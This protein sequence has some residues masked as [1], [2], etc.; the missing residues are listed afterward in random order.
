M[1]VISCLIVDDEPLAVQLLENHIEQMP[2]LH[3]EGSCSNAMEALQFI[4]S[5]SVD[6]I[7]L[8]IQ[9]PMLSGVDFLKSIKNPPK[10]IFTT[11]FREY[12]LTGYE[13][14]IVDYLLKPITFDRF[15]KA[16]NKYIKLT[17]NQLNKNINSALENETDSKSYIF[18]NV[19][20]K[21][22]KI[23]FEDICY[24]ESLKDY[25]KIHLGDEE[26]LT[27]EKISDFEDKLPA[28][29][30]RIHRSFI[31]NKE[32]ITAFTAQDVEIG[33]QEIPIGIS[34]KRE[35]ESWL[36]P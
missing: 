36:K 9:M 12:A 34:Y 21:Y 1:K 4:E 16:I 7:L 32:K 33:K 35:V 6:L 17:D 26:V 31:V 20:K 23:L 8:D 2:M 14:D 28:N 10:V 22:V 13:L 15:F 30:K 27:K 29:F 5:H 3:L 25:I 19:N 11:A 18:V 24:V